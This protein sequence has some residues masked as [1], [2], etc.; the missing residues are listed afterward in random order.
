MRIFYLMT[1]YVLKFSCCIKI[2]TD[3]KNDIAYNM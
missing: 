3:V 1:L 2:D